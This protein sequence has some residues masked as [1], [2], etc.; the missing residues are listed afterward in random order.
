MTQDTTPTDAPPDDPGGIEELQRR[1]DELQSQ[2]TQGAAERDQLGR[3]AAESANL[4]RATRALHA[5]GV[6]DMETAEALLGRRMDL[7]GQLD[8]AALTGGV[9]ALLAEKPFLRTAPAAVPPLP[10]ASAGVR[11]DDADA[12]PVQRAAEQAARSGNRRD[13]AEYLRLRRNARR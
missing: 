10:P 11:P 12:G 13:L 3:Q 5:A 6:T 1:L 4:L 9:E 7:A 2:V 8:D